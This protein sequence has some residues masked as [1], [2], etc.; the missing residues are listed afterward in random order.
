MG[1]YSRYKAVEEI[2]SGTKKIAA[3]YNGMTKIW[4]V[5]EL[6]SDC[7]DVYGY[8]YEALAVRGDGTLYRCGPENSHTFDEAMPIF[9]KL[10]GATNVKEAVLGG[11]GMY[12]LTNAGT[13]FAKGENESGEFGLGDS[14]AKR[15]FTQLPL[16]GIKRVLTT[17]YGRTCVA[18]RSDGTLLGCG[19]NRNT[20]QAQSFLGLGTSSGINEF[21]TIRE[22]V[23]KSVYVSSTHIVLHNDGTMTFSGSGNNAGEGGHV[24]HNTWTKSSFAHKVKKLDG[25]E[26]HSLIITDDSYNR[27]YGAA[28]S[29][30]SKQ[31]PV[32]TLSPS[33]YLTWDKTITENT[34]DV[35]CSY[36]GT[37]IERENGELW[38]C[39]ANNFGQAGVGH[40]E[41]PVYPME[42]IVN[43]PGTLKKICGNSIATFFLMTD[44]RLFG[45]GG[46]EGYSIGLGK[47]QT[48]LELTQLTRTR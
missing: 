41:S 43:L 23:Q 14:S 5:Y 35:Y 33:Y 7:V 40:A 48:Y 9:T 6:L 13:V 10:E 17:I 1:I 36:M 42:R 8:S 2:Y 22:N 47:Q 25:G 37:F 44:G 45:V 32:D 19:R 34:K 4:P 11:S 16:S 38:T 27:T 26:T 3:V 24:F 20:N 31:I 18:L 29:N 15:S 39:G 28:P 21:Q 46:K 30:T 12:Y